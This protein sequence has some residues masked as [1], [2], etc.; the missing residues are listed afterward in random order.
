MRLSIYRCVQV[1]RHAVRAVVGRGVRMSAMRSS[2]AA[3]IAATFMCAP[4][5]AQAYVPVI[6]AWRVN[7]TGAVGFNNLAA[8]VQQVR[9]SSTYVYVNSSSV[10]SYP[11][12][13][14]MGSP[15]TVINQNF[16]FRILRTPVVKTGTKTP[17]GLGNIGIWVN[18]VGIFNYSDGRSYNNKNIWHNDAI[19]VE[20][21]SFDSC[22]GHPSPNNEYHN[23]QNAACL[24]SESNQVHSPIVGYA[25]DSFPIY[26]PYA[27]SNTDG[28]G[29]IKKMGSG[30]SLRNMTTRTTLPNGT[31][32][33]SANYGPAVST[34]YPLGYFAE[35]YIYSATNADLDLNNVRFCVTPEY[36]N[37]TYA[38][39]VT[40]TESGSPAYPYIVGPSYHGVFDN[41]NAGGKVTVPTGVTTYDPMDMDDSGTLDAGD[42]SLVLLNFGSY[43]PGDFDGSGDVGP[44]DLGILL[45]SM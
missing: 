24:F 41:S 32:L 14:W 35:D 28:S 42:I 19:R 36:P 43:G 11:I 29:G 18:G 15:N 23:H 27:Y 9:Y 33:S 3:S 1:V 22:G 6:S 4:T 12:G 25:F 20:G 39:F 21:P 40:L 31:V 34:T 44:G 38:Y 8:D 45:L 26:G 16:S 2:I 7:L 10:P 30:Y 37:G 5:H 13:P 17:T